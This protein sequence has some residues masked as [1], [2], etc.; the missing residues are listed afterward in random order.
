MYGA[1]LE[2]EWIHE[3]MNGW[4]DGW[5]YDAGVE[6]EWINEWINGWMNGCNRSMV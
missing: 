1:G 2:N 6:N 3:R 5:M 4:M